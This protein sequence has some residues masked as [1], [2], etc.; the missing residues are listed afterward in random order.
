MLLVI[1][2]G[3]TSTVIGVY[4][5]T[6][7]IQH[8]RI[9]TKKARTA[10]EYGIMLMGLFTFSRTEPSNIDGAIISSVVP[11]L[12]EVFLNMEKRYFKINPLIIGPGI[13]TG[14]PILTDNPKEVGAD[15][16]V[17]AV[18]AFERYKRAVIVVDFGTATTFDYISPKGEYMGGAITPGM[19]ISLDAL[20]QRAAK[21]PRIELVKP[22]R[23]VGKDTVE[24]MQAGIFFG[25][26]GLID[27]VVKRMKE[28]VGGSPTVVATGG[29]ANIIVKECDTI[30]EFDEFLTLDGLRIIYNK[31]Q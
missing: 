26:L 14:M 22:K 23:V 25:Y 30:E 7:L 17:N 8:W 20:F 11:P 9:G 15:R 18:A 1:D 21:L 27:K 12:T 16:I 13:R 2:I 6:S 4:D 10:D 5:N 28:E 29:S 19:S 3:N 31:N 24:S